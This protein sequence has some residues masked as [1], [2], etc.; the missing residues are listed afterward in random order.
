MTWCPRYSWGKFGCTCL[1]ACAFAALL[2]APSSAPGR[3]QP[4]ELTTYGYGNSRLGSSPGPIGISSRQTRGLHKAWRANLSGAIDGQPIIV[5]GVKVGHRAR[6]LVLV[7]TGHGEVAAVDVGNGKTLWIRHV[8]SRRLLPACLAS[9]DARFGVTETLVADR[10]ASVVYAVDVNGRA[11]AFNVSSGKTVRGWPVR[12]FAGSPQF[13]WGALALSDGRLYIPTASEC[14]NGTYYGS[15]VSINLSTRQVTRWFSTRGTGSF[16]GGIWGWG[17]E[18]IETGTGDVFVG[19]GNGMGTPN[20]HSAYAEQV[21]RF[22]PALHVLQSNYPLRPPFDEP[23]RD[24]GTAPLLIHRAGCQ[25]QLVTFDKDG[26]LYRYA[27]DHLNRGPL[28]G[29]QVAST[30]DSSIPLYGMA[31]YDPGRHRL[32]LTSPTAAPHGRRKGIQSYILNRHCRL[33]Y[34]WQHGFDNPS[35]GSAPTIAQGVLYLGSGRNGILRAYRL[36]NGG[37]LWHHVLGPTIFAA[38]A[39]ADGTVFAADWSGHLWAFRS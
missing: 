20:E 2:I 38:P 7:G 25:E 34:G 10:A 27:A 11:W 4:V 37:E 14:G 39:A 3:G 1:L 26:W 29:I 13:D 23:D 8:G 30:T 6:N 28:Q 33:V 15:L 32:V 17:G 24:F 36:S 19:T 18:A 21:L 16:G 12:A 9:P 22:T 35:A 5:N 31:A